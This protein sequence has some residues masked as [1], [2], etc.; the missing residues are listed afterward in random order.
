MTNLI[1]AAAL[2]GPLKIPQLDRIA[3]VETGNLRHPHNSIGDEGK[4]F[5]AWQIQ[6]S[7]WQ[8]ANKKLKQLGHSRQPIKCFSKPEVSRKQAAAYTMVLC[9]RFHEETGRECDW[10]DLYVMW[11]RGL[12]GYR[13]IHF[14]QERVPP[15]LTKK[16]R[17]VRGH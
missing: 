15:A 8:A 11:N 1:L 17:F 5:G 3:Q 12:S 6:A 4:S 9:E 2:L 14:M 10:F 7:S 13:R 16:A